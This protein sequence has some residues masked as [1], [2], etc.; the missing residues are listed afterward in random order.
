MDYGTAISESIDYTKE[1]VWGKWAKWAL[2]VIST[3]IFPLIMGYIV[4]IYSGAK[5]APELENWGSLFID[6][7]KLFIIGLIYAIPVFIVMVIFGGSAVALSAA[8]GDAPSAAALGSLAVGLLIA[9]IVGIIIS[10]IAAIGVIRFARKDSLGEAF[11]IGA[12]LEHIGRIG[13]GTYIIALIILWLV[14]IVF[15]II[16]NILG[17]IP[18]LG[19]LIMLF[20]YPA[21]TIFAARYM[22]HIYDSAPAPA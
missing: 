18:I 17:M 11:A 22:V 9:V 12:I 19:W 2:L 4:R 1:A 3:I 15:S 8:G 21:W 14:G 6:G 16:I 7:L 10:L 20:L 5:P 13:W